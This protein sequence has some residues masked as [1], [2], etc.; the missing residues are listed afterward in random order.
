[1]VSISKHGKAR[2]GWPMPYNADPHP[3]PPHPDTLTLTPLHPDP[4][5]CPMPYNAASVP[6]VYLSLI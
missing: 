5:G 6:S 1:M 3:D 2:I 4:H